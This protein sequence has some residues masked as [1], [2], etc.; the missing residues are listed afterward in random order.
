VT[1]AR[2]PMS[3]L[4]TLADRWRD[5][6]NRL[7]SSPRF[8]RWAAAFPLTRPIARQRASAVFDLVAG[9]VY[10]QI[11]LACVRL[12][13][14]EIL[15]DGSQ[16]LPALS[17]RLG[18]STE[19]TRRLLDAAVA[20]D[21]CER[22][23]KDEYAHEYALGPLGAPLVG[24]RA[25]A[26]MIEHHAMLYADLRDPVALL[27]GD[28]T[29]GAVAAYWPYAGADV[30]DRLSEDRIAAYTQLMSSSQPL[31]ADEILN[32]YSFAHHRCLLDVGG[33]DGTF[34]TT[35]ARR[36]PHLKL[37]LFD[38]PAVAQ[39]A[40]AKF[41]KAGLSDRTEVTGGNFLVDRLPD[42]A[43][44]ISLVRVVHDHD[45]ERVIAL[46]RAARAALPLGGALLIA[47]PMSATP[48][49]KAMGD[50]YFSFYL[51][52]MGGGRPRTSSRLIDML[53]S[54]GFGS[55]RILPTGQPLQTSLLLATAVSN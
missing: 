40:R 20:L 48:G 2:M 31:V 35:V 27:R 53:K 17:L 4:D 8:H 29:S 30:P 45:D 19:A 18:L 3:W 21:L 11:L 44:I 10:T 1:A 5:S 55:P 23:G 12:N 26:A 14:F 39:H 37:Q 51:L 46:L 49:A 22:R 15:R 36:H 16:A 28:P 54:S 32:A 34:L 9:F 13:L 33:G 42:G 25:I 7:L 50:A 41:A 47:E 38:L 52:A 24:N 43:D 6:R